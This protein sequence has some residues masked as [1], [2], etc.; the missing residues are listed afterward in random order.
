MAVKFTN[1][2][3]TTLAA[4]INSSVTSIAVTDG[5]VFP[6]ITGSDHFYVTFDDTTNKE[7][8]KVTARSGN[9]LTVVRG[10]DNT[11]A[12]AFSSGDKAEL[13]IVAA[14]LDDVKTDVSSTLTVDTFTGNG[15]ATAFTLSVA[16]AS[17]DN[18]IVFIEGVY[19]NPGDFTLSGTTLTFD[20]APA[21]SRN[22]IVYHVAALVSGN[23]LTHNQFTCNG[24]TTAFTLG[25][26]PIH[27]NN[28][29]VFLDGVYQQKTDYAVSGTTL[30]MDTA[31][32]NGAILEVM[33]FTQTEVNTLPASF[34]S[35]LTEVTAVGAD[36]FMIFDATDSALKKSLVSDVLE[37]A[38]SISTSADATAITIDS[39]EK[40][41]FTSDV[42]T[43]G[44][45]SVGG[46]N[47]ELRFY[48]GSNYVGFEAPAL[49][50]DKIWVLPA[51]DG[52]NGQVIKTDGSGN[53]SFTTIDT[54]ISA[55]S[56]GITELNVSDGS[57]GQVLQTNGSGTLSFATVSGGP[58]HKEGGTNFTNSIMIGD[59]S[60]GTLSSA[61]RN[62]GVGKD[63]FASLTSGAGNNVLGYQA[64][65]ANTTGNN[66]VAIGETALGANTTGGN[67][68]GIGHEALASSTT[69][70]NNVAIGYKALDAATTGGSNTAVGKDAL[71]DLTT[72]SE[73]VGVGWTAGGDITTARFCTAVGRQA[74]RLNTTTEYLTAVG[75]SAARS[76]TGETMAAFGTHAAYSNTTGVSNTAIGAYAL[77]NCTTANRNTAL[78]HR[79]GH[80]YTG[81]ENVF[82][83]NEAGEGSSSGNFN[84]FVGHQAGEATNGSSNI[85]L[86]NATSI[87]SASNR[88]VIGNSNNGTGTQDYAVAFVRGN[89]DWSRILM[90]GTSIS[91]S[92]D[93]RKKKDIT[94]HALGLSFINRLR[95]VNFK[96]KAPSDFPNTFTDYDSEIT[97]PTRTGWET[98]FIAQ[99]V[100]A[101]MDAEGIETEKFNGW[102]VEADGSQSLSPA[103]LIM[104]LVKA[105]QEADDKI[106]ALTARIETLEG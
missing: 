77:Y 62:T 97:T 17:E 72:G 73:N 38:T 46:N 103:Q 80:G 81:S 28:T 88:Y 67:N 20:V 52:S 13:R 7:I 98:G 105:L 12:R 69:A 3:A 70:S 27:E 23:N 54:S 5:S 58:T 22:I 11:T 24:S 78:G 101:A 1:N 75:Y 4:G 84:T 61:E 66:N 87:G 35:G 90:G 57:N 99:E 82:I 36:H 2:A 85:I 29:Q 74:L 83:G 63:V 51:A 42:T 47:N 10:H 71:G 40:V 56:V 45:L 86:G 93:E 31:P 8:V 14:L 106:D 6:T 18:L 48:E 55:N 21:N 43:G 30:T 94:N 102:G 91:A 100:K 44:H 76:C 53:L 59:D 26:S 41:T 95:P 39:N 16:P 79:A 92:S 32:A 50:A 49:S 25:L 64:L 96:W 9:T 65:D 104:P 33:T 34:V 37:S 19:Q 68:V 15:S 89:S 60:T